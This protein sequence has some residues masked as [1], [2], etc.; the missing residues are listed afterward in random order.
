MQQFLSFR[1]RALGREV[2]VLPML[3]FGLLWP[4]SVSAAHTS[5]ECPAQTGTVAAGGK[6]S[7]NITNCATMMGLAGTG[8]VDGPVFP[9][10]GSAN[11]RITGNK[12]FLDYSHRGN[13]A[14]SDVF[15]FTDGTIAGNTVR[16]SITIS[17]AK[18]KA[19][20]RK[21]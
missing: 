11:L 8:G 2:L 15:E 6:V 1:A 14:T 19:T 17:K 12:W 21:T 3:C 18:S 13:S 20:A 4:F 10:S 16:V 5:V 7:I 9:A